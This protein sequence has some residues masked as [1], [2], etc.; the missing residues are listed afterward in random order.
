MV[1]LF[2]WA[3]RTCL[4]HRHAY[5]TEGRHEPGRRSSY[6]ESVYI[7]DNIEAHASG[8]EFYI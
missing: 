6:L 8:I 1:L 7:I 3:V 2:Y 5:G 4:Y